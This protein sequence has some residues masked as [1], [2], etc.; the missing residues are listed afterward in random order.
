MTVVQH[1]EGEVHV[2]NAEVRVESPSGV[3]MAAPD[4]VLHYVIEHGY[5][6]P[7]E[8]VEAV[9]HGSRLEQ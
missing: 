8:F 5:K 9:M 3:K 4:M 1:P 7:V 2:G 6:P